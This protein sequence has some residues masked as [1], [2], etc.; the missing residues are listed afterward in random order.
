MSKRPQSNRSE[1]EDPCKEGPGRR[2]SVGR[3][4]KAS[5][6]AEQRIQALRLELNS[7]SLLYNERLREISERVTESET[8]R[9]QNRQYLATLDKLVG[10]QDALLEQP[11]Q[12]IQEVRGE[13]QAL[14]SDRD[15]QTQLIQEVRGEIQDLKAQMDSVANLAD[16][17]L[18]TRLGKVLRLWFRP[19]RVTLK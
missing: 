4:K 9:E 13:I 1:I 15:Q 8:L 10:S 17:F 5:A 18:S 6:T 3:Q 12:L 11:T 19:S 14:R 2:S 7:K 16:R